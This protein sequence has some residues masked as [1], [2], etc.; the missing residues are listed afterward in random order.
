MNIG[1]ANFSV[2]IER[3]EAIILESKFVNGH[4]FWIENPSME[5]VSQNNSDVFLVISRQMKLIQWYYLVP[6]PVIFIWISF[7][8]P[9]D[10]K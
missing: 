10:K 5:L 1:T 7:L 8:Y 4:T 3:K 9:F 6:I 2:Q